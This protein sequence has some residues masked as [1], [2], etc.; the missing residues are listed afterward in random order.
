MLATRIEHIRLRIVSRR[1]TE[2]I[3]GPDTLREVYQLDTPRSNCCLY[4][5][6]SKLSTTQKGVILS[7]TFQKGV[8]R[9][10]H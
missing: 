9:M 10:T 8:R 1:H 4:I 3:A 6:R 2:G 7:A 5:R